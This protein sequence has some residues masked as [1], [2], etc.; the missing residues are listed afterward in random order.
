MNS[1]WL[2]RVKANIFPVSFEKK[3]VR[4]ALNEWVY[5]GN[6]YDVEVAEEMCELCDQPHIRFQFEILNIIN[7]NTLQIGSECI[8][9]FNIGVVDRRGNVLSP[10]AAKRKVNKDR[11]KLITDAKVKSVIASL[12]DLARDDDDFDIHNFIRYFKDNGAFT[13]KQLVTL[14]W[15]MEKYKIEHN[16]SHFKI[17]IKKNKDKEQLLG[18]EEWKVQKIWPCLS[19]SQKKYYIENKNKDC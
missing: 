8:K 14:I 13:P 12:V 16:K 3:N 10:D 6:V 15:R 2:E 18:L 4:K 1:H 17:T 11:N 19:N 5:Q 7:G 9:R